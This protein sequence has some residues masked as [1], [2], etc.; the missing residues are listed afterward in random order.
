MPIRLSP[1][2]TSAS[3]RLCSWTFISTLI[4]SS[5]NHS[6]SSNAFSQ[7]TLPAPLTWKRPAGAT[8]LSAAIARQWESRFVS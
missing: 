5:H 3:V 1:T 2:A 6:Q 8:G 4:F 7:T